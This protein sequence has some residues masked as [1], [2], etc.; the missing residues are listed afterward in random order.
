MILSVKPRLSVLYQGETIIL[1][2]VYLIW[3]WCEIHV[4]HTETDLTFILA[5]NFSPLQKNVG[6]LGLVLFFF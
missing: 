1:V 2:Q 3:A 4:F 6:V 5:P